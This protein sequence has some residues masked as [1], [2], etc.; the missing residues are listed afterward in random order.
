MIKESECNRKNTK[1]C[2]A[3][4]VPS[5]KQFGCISYYMLLSKKQ[6]ILFL[7]TRK[8]FC[9][10][11]GSPTTAPT[12]GYSLHAIARHGF[13]HL[14]VGKCVPKN[15]NVHGNNTGQSTKWTHI[16]FFFL[17]STIIY[18]QPRC[19]T[20]GRFGSSLHVHNA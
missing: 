17:L 18:K 11:T 16:L 5:Q 15:Y 20:Q 7:S 4:V 9:F 19:L 14:M 10:C 1:P 3:S 2:Q 8:Y 13:V 6:C 12:H